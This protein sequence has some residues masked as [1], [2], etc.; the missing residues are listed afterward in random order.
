MEV[1]PEIYAWLVNIKVLDANKSIKINNDGKILVPENVVR[2]LMVG[3]YFDQ[4]LV[5][6]Q[7]GYNKF[8]K[9]KLNYTDRLNDLKLE[10]SD[11]V[12]YLPLNLRNSNWSIISEVLT[13]FGIE[14]SKR[15]LEKITSGNINEL[16]ELLNTIYILSC[17]LFKKSIDNSIELESSIGNSNKSNKKSQINNQS[18]TQITNTTIPN[19]ISFSLQKSVGMISNNET[20]DLNTFDAN[21]DYLNCQSPL[22]FLIVSLSKIFT[23]KPRQSVALLS[24]NRKY[25]RHI[26]NKGIKGEFEK[27]SQWYY[28]LSTNMKIFTNLLRTWKNGRAVGF[29]TVSVGLYSKNY[30]IAIKAYNLLA[31][32]LLDIGTD[33]EWFSKEGILAIVFCINKHEDLRINLINLIYD[34]SRKNLNELCDVFDLRLINEK[35]TEKLIQFL[36]AIVNCLKQTDNLI[37]LKLKEYLLNSCLKETLDVSAAVSILA[38]AWINFYPLD[39]HY[40]NGIVS[41]MKNAV[42]I[43]NSNSALNA[44]VNDMSLSATTDSNSAPKS[45]KYLMISISSVI[46]VFR[47]LR[48]FKETKKED[49]TLLYKILVFLFLENSDQTQLREVFLQHFADFFKKDRSVLIKVLVDPYLRQIKTTLN[50]DLSDFK[51]LNMIMSLDYVRIETYMIKNILEFVL[52]VSK[53]DIRFNKCAC[54]ILNK[55]IDKYF[56]QSNFKLSQTQAESSDSDLC[57]ICVNHIKSTLEIFSN[58]IKNFPKKIDTSLLESLYYVISTNISNINQHVHDDIVEVNQYFRGEFNY[59]STGL[60]SLLWFYDDHDEVLLNLEEKFSDRNESIEEYIEEK[61]VKKPAK[62]PNPQADIEKIKSKK[63]QKEIQKMEENYEKQLRDVKIKTL[64]QKK[65]EQ[66]SFELG[67]KNLQSGNNVSNFVSTLANNSSIA[68]LSAL[69]SKM[70]MIIKEGINS[71]ILNNNKFNP[72]RNFLIPISLQDEEDR[73]NRAI[74]GLTKEF[75]K[76]IKHYFK[77]YLTEINDTVTKANFLKMLRD[78]GIGCDFLTLEELTISVRNLFGLPLN[79]FT[80]EQFVNLIIQISYLIMTKMNN[81]L[82]LSECFKEILSMFKIPNKVTEK[83]KKV[84]NIIKQIEEKLETT[85]ITVDNSLDKCH[86]QDVGNEEIENKENNK[87]NI[88]SIENPNETSNDLIQNRILLPP[89]FRQSFKYKVNYDHKL[90]E[91]FLKFLPESKFICIEILNDIIRDS[92]GCNIL[93]SF[94]KIE[95][96]LEITVDPMRSKHKKWSLAILNAYSDINP[97]F[98]DEAE[99]TADILEDMLRAISKGSTSLKKEKILGPLEKFEIEQSQ[100]L[101]EEEK[102]K[103]KK[104]Q[105]RI[106]FLKKNLELKQKEK[107]Y[108]IKEKEEKAKQKKEAR[109]S[110]LKDQL[111]EEKKMRAL[112]S[113]KIKNLKK[114][115]EEERKRKELEEIEKKEEQEKRKEEER[116]KFLTKQK[117]KI[118]E[119]LSKIRT[120]KEEFTKRQK[121]NFDIMFKIPKDKTFQSVITE[122]EKFYGEFERT[123]NSKLEEIMSENEEIRSTFENYE[124]HLKL[125]FDIYYQI[126]R[127]IGNFPEEI[128]YFKAFKE[129]CVNFTIVSLLISKEQMQYIFNKICKRNEGEGELQ[130]FFRYKDFLLSIFYISIFSKFTN[131]MK[132]IQPEDIEQIK[133]ENLRIFFEFLGLKLPFNKIEVEEFINDRRALSAK[134]LMKLQHQ[135]KKEKVKLIKGDFDSNNEEIIMKNNFLSNRNQ[136]KIP[137]RKIKNNPKINLTGNVNDDLVKESKIV[138]VDLMTLRNS[139]SLPPPDNRNQNTIQENSNVKKISIRNPNGKKEEWKVKS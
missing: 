38:D 26:C 105:Q 51:F 103:E 50:Y 120:M 10:R 30:N 11:R 64:L 89:G 133:A 119:Q 3:C 72:F 13:N 116:E 43:F 21:K 22:E 36:G 78:I 16:Y 100:K 62:K 126:G 87:E 63:V 92:L 32:L 46:N 67:I 121:E 23:M 31:Q 94:V 48:R 122:K 93:E 109:D 98:E 45:E 124:N 80:K 42:R 35:S 115:K 123:L 110:K 71:S 47:I 138:P 1:T 91:N 12:E 112:M 40:T 101:L 125:I 132:K 75:H 25:L 8:Y 118:R 54:T 33:W 49:Y 34:F 4:I 52:N 117:H 66:K 18:L 19:N 85:K 5:H 81:R 61:K 113:E 130:N 99:E 15:K 60:L 17:E 14:V 2:N 114:E 90:P 59:Y 139:Q 86:P 27:I 56:D 58:N 84:K 73:E 135:L 134:G 41:Y 131:K 6:L 108:E 104:R 96:S 129:F 107:L 65:L 74:T 79:V 24:N 106:Q 82:T 44:K 127:K 137:N 29:A 9:I 39:K 111:I 77:N 128:M 7:E 70:T 55:I 28:E 88:D 95:K 69:G 83:D 53:T 57:I 136:D 37:C 97:S 102:I 68:N 20:I 76:E